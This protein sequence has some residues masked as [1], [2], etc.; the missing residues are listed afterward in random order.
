MSPRESEVITSEPSL[1]SAPGNS[2]K[3]EVSQQIRPTVAVYVEPL[4]A[5]SA[6][7]VRAQA[8]A[9]LEFD[10]VYVSPKR[11]FP[12]LEIPGERSVVICNNPAAPRAWNWLKQ[13]PLKVFGCAP[14]FFHRVQQHQPVLVHAHFGPAA[15][16]ALPMVHWLKVPMIVTFHGYDATVTDACLERAHYRARIYARKRSVLQKEAN[17]FISVS[18]FIRK[19]ILEQGFPED[20]VL[21][22][23][24][25]VDTNFFRPVPEIKRGPIVLFTAT[26]TEK[27]GC[28]Y[29]IQAMREVQKEEPSVE[30]VVIGD[31]DLRSK[32]EQLAGKCLRNYRFIGTQPPEIVRD[33]MNRA[34]VFCVPSIRARDGDGEGFGM[35]FAE[36]QAMGL[37]VASFSSGG[38]PEAVED[39]VT[40]LLA[41]EK[42]WRSLASHISALLRNKNLWLRMSEAGRRRIR[43]SFDL[44]VQTARLEDIY[45]R[46]LL[47]NRR[48]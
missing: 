30:L 29:L 44:A 32:L 36:A 34:S 28:A 19:Q 31:G 21:V 1:D 10:P 18:E 43:S 4:L 39:G 15:L 41:P 37:P 27:K 35:V 13:I 48:T 23:Y 22:H 12:S 6:T 38:V 42:D 45:K 8:S 17:L 26:L 46:V 9:M 16:T 5:P 20:R 14:I 7:F 2:E 25:G 40:G 3:H 33:W 24:I 47:E 11:A